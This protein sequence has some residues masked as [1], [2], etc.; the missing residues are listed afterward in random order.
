MLVCIWEPHIIPKSRKIGSFSSKSV[1]EYSRRGMQV[2]NEDHGKS[3][4]RNLHPAYTPEGAIQSV[5]LN[6]KQSRP[7][8]FKFSKVT[9]ES[10][11]EYDHALLENVY[12]VKATFLGQVL[13]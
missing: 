5:G 6:Q 7:F 11:A 12:T 8:L 3:Y 4:V 2:Q 13:I 10:T 9:A 1:Q